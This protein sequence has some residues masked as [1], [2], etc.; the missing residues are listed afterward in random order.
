MKFKIEL[1]L[2]FEIVD[3]VDFDEN[4]YLDTMAELFD[5]VDEVDD[6][7]YILLYESK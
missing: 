1:D 6:D 2:D 7:G 4:E 5:L 3:D